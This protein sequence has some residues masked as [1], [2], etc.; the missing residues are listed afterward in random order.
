MIGRTISI[1]KLLNGVNHQVSTTFTYN[2][3]AT[4]PI[5]HNQVLKQRAGR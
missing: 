2:R 1:Q 4:L 5:E 3:S